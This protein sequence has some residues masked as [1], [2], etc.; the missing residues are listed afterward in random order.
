MFNSFAIFLLLS[1]YV[2]ALFRLF[3]LN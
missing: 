1:L 2:L 3:A